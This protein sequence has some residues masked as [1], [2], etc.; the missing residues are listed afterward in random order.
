MTELYLHLAPSVLLKY[1]QKIDA[2]YVTSGH[3][4][5]IVI[6]SECS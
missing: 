5:L 3:L 4:F 6:V 1:Y 2:N